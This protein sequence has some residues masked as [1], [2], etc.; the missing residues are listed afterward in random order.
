MHLLALGRH[1]DE[2]S[3][4]ELPLMSRRSAT[5][6]TASSEFQ[7]VGGR[8]ESPFVAEPK[9]PKLSLLY[10]LLVSADSGCFTASSQLN[11]LQVATS[12]G[13]IMYKLLARAEVWHVRI[14]LCWRHDPE[15]I[16][17]AKAPRS[18]GL[19]AGCVPGISS[20]KARR[21]GSGG[22]F[23]SCKRSWFKGNTIVCR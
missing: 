5:E 23:S 14:Q 7:S 3:L 15:V 16:V 10:N 20:G 4:C 9:I 6:S 1:L 19:R 8:K 11:F 13:L 21:A 17:T 18:W 2:R 12:G 22:S